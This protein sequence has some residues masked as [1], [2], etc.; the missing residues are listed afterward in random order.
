VEKPAC[1]LSL[2]AVTCRLLSLHV[3]AALF[4]FQLA[5]LWW[6]PFFLW[7]RWWI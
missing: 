2:A 4:T 1:S 3:D 6:T 7:L 5:C